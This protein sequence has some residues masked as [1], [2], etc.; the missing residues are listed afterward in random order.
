[1]WHGFCYR[2]ELLD[3][4]AAT[5]RRGRPQNSDG[6]NLRGIDMNKLSRIAL[7]LALSGAAATASAVEISGNVTLAS[8][9]RFRGISQLEGEISP[10]LQGGFDL[11]HESGFYAGVWGSNVNFTSSYFVE[12]EDESV[13]KFV[14]TYSPGALELDVYGGYKGT[15]GDL[16]YDIGV[17]YY[18]YPDDDVTQLDYVEVYGSLD[19]AGFTVGVN[20][21][22]DYF[23]ESGKFYYLH[24]GYTYQINETL[25]VA[26]HLGYNSFDEEVFLGDDDDYLD[27]SV[28]ITWTALGVDWGLTY[29]DTDLDDDDEC[30]GAKDLCDATVVASISKSL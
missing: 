3:V 25:S 19:F 26:A 9:Y 22:D 20:Y 4:A 21:S 8:D 1:M 2:R 16:G 11:E 15:V 23:A 17:M 28:G 14:E 12:N 18:A 13:D 10:A 7:G 30:F 29:V 5:P 24:G 6:L 27:W